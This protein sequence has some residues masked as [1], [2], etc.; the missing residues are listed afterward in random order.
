[1]GMVRFSFVVEFINQN[2][3]FSN[4]IVNYRESKQTFYNLDSNP[5][6]QGSSE[7]HC[8]VTPIMISIYRYNGLITPLEAFFMLAKL[9]ALQGECFHASK[10][11]EERNWILQIRQPCVT[12]V[13]LSSCYLA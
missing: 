8:P 5:R 12:E 3:L 4:I 6:L 1:M 2:K 11:C 13:L 10:F 7:R 9:F